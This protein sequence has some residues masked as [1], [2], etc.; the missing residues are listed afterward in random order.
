MPMALIG[1]LFDR[2]KCLLFSHSLAILNLP[3]LTAVSS[4]ERSP[5]S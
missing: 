5:G 3:S 1:L 4:T 2:A